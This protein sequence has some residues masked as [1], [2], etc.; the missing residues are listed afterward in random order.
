MYG[1]SAWFSIT[2]SA[3][4]YILDY[5]TKHRSFCNKLQFTFAPEETYIPTILLHSPLK[6]NIENNN[7]RYIDWQFRNDSVP[8]FL[9]ESDFDKIMDSNIFFARKVHPHISKN[10]I[11]KIDEAI[12]MGD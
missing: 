6:N 4:E 1:G 5:T 9:D 7:L 10:L 3:V 2:R 8:A 11:N 12:G